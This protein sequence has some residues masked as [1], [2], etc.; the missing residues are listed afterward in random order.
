MQHTWKV[1]VL[2]VVLSL[3]HD[4]ETAVFAEV[5]VNGWQQ[6][7]EL[8]QIGYMAGVLDVATNL[9]WFGERIAGNRGLTTQDYWNQNPDSGAFAAAGCPAVQRLP[10][11]QKMAILRKYVTN[12]PKMWEGPMAIMIIAAFAELCK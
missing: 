7:P 2:I 9:A 8:S 3:Y 11:N 10:V 5:D 12:N 1:L 6:L 4:A